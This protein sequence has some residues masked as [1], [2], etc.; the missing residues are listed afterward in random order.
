VDYWNI[1][2]QDA[3]S[4]ISS[5]NIVNSCYDA[6]SLNNP[7]CDLIERNGETTSAQSGGLTFL[8][9]AQLNFGSAEATGWDF[10]L[11]YGL[12]VGGFDLN[13]TASATLQT[14]LDFVQP[15]TDGGEANVDDELGE[16][17]R[18]EWSV[19]AKLSAERGAVAVN[20]QTQYLSR[21]VLAF[22]DGAEIETVDENFGPDGFSDETFIHV[23]TGSYQLNDRFTF[24]GGIDNVTDERPFITERAYPVGPRGRYFFAGMNVRL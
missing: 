9:Q 4:S 10:T 17:R 13:F 1:D 16:S 23:L 7:F 5:Q 8:R 22:E 20:W 19:L 24:Y 6:A 18:P 11:G 15:S 12:N 2:I 3:I 21:Q 14:Q